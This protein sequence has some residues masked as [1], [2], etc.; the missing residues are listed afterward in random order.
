MSLKTAIAGLTNKITNMNSATG[1]TNGSLKDLNQTMGAMVNQLKTSMQMDQRLTLANQSLREFM[2]KNASVI[3][4]NTA[5]VER[6]TKIAIETQMMGLDGQRKQLVNTAGL[7]ALT[8]QNTMGLLKMVKGLE[9]NTTMNRAGTEDLVK[10]VTESSRKYGRTTELLIESM[11]KL[12]STMEIQTALGVDTGATQAVVA[13]LTAKFGATFGQQTAE[14]INMLAAMDA[15]QAAALGVLDE[16]AMVRSGQIGDMGATQALA[17]LEGAGAKIVQRMEAIST[18]PRFAPEARASLID[19]G[20]QARVQAFVAGSMNKIAVTISDIDRMTENLKVYKEK[21]ELPAQMIAADKAERQ[22]MIQE[23]LT[24]M[25]AGFKNMMAVFE[26][27]TKL[28]FTGVEKTMTLI[29]VVFMGAGF[30]FAK[31]ID[32]MI[33]FLQDL[34]ML[35]LDQPYQSLWT[36]ELS[37]SLSM[38]WDSL[39]GVE[40]NTRTANDRAA[41]ADAERRA[42]ELEA[43]NAYTRIRLENAF[44][45]NVDERLIQHVGELV[46]YMREGND[47]NAANG[48]RLGN[49]S[50]EEQLRRGRGRGR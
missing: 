3:Q 48:R 45:Y 9:T 31:M 34:G 2:G 17:V 38:M 37:N 33:E 42:S 49:L 14:M 15:G 47:I 32:K 28:L 36:E 19:V 12:S 27:V 22:M 20:G 24:N 35:T 11:E 7:M 5:G 44:R 39:R 29:G 4:G 13:E 46:T 25:I 21:V 1:I 10:A 18:D 43:T 41:A 50:A 40:N 8:G 16:Q 30:L 26:P 23:G 6:S